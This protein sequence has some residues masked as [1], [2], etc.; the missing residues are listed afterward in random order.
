MKTIFYLNYLND[1]TID[2]Y[3]SYLFD[4][5]DLSRVSRLICGDN[6]NT[7]LIT[8]EDK[9]T[10]LYPISCYDKEPIYKEYLFDTANK[11]NFNTGTF[12]SPGY[13]KKIKMANYIYIVTDNDNDSIESIIK[14]ATEFNK[15]IVKYK[16]QKCLKKH[17]Q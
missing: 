1:L 15:T 5:R 6:I 2:E 3:E 8:K 17:K 12:S 10:L 14:A 11:Y 16:V 4:R 9:V 7:A 13:L